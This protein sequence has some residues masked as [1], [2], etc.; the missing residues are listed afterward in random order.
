MAIVIVTKLWDL[1]NYIFNRYWHFR[2][3]GNAIA[4]A[5]Y[6]YPKGFKF[7]RN[8]RNFVPKPGDMAVWERVPIIMV[9]DIQLL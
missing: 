3:T 9:Q 1:P 8:T 6:R 7:Y 5:W 2:T 4:M